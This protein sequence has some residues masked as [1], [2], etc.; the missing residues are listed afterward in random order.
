M[1]SWSNCICCFCCCCCLIWPNRFADCEFIPDCEMSC[2]KKKWAYRQHRHAWMMESRHLQSVANVT[3][4]ATPQSS[5][6]YSYSPPSR[7]ACS[8]PIIIEIQ[9]QLRV[10]HVYNRQITKCSTRE[11]VTTT[12]Q[13]ILNLCMLFFQKEK[14]YWIQFHEKHRYFKI[15][16]ALSIF[17]IF[18]ENG[19][20]NSWPH[21]HFYTFALTATQLR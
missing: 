5:C 2:L 6:S 4:M 15:S 1:R 10:S 9:L 17:C 7:V 19:K 18:N 16:F 3:P 13:I 14:S 21:M 20:D 12:T 8:Q 11:F